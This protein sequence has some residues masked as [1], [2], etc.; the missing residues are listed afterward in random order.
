V[1]LDIQHEQRRRK[2]TIDIQRLGVSQSHDQPQ[3]Q[4]QEKGGKQNLKVANS[5]LGFAKV[6]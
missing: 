1:P 3:L 2:S 5:S 6:S 4:R